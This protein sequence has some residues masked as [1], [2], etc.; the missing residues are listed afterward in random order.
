M[1]K[2][3]T[4]VLCTALAA[5]T[6]DAGQMQ[7]PLAAGSGG[8]GAPAGTGGAGGAGGASGAGGMG[9][10]GSGGM[11]PPLDAGTGGQAG[12]S[13]GM[14]GMGGA[15]GAS[16]A[17]M[18]DA[19]DR[20]DVTSEL[21]VIVPTAEWACGLPSGIPAP[22]DGELVAT[23][24]LELQAPLE[25]GA[26]PF[27]ERS[28]LLTNAGTVSGELEGTVV[29]GGY[30]WELTLP[31]GARELETRH[32]LRIG[33]ALIY[34]RG[35]GVGTASGATR[36]IMA[37]EVSGS[38]SNA[39]FQSGV[40]VATRTVRAGS[41]RFSIHRF[42]D[43][44]TLDPAAPSLTIERTARDRALKPQPWECAP[45][46][47]G[48]SEGNQLIEATVA[49]GS[50]LA[51]GSTQNGS[52]NIIPITGGSFEGLGA[53]SALSGEVIP[54]GADFQLTPPGG[55][56]QLEAR[57]T[58]RAEDGTL[59]A[60]RNCGGVGGTAPYF[61][62]PLASSYAYLNDGDYFGRIGI[63]IGA[64]IISVFERVP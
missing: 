36:V 30:D 9:S 5:C 44:F 15:A 48:S 58:L 40:Y 56:F 11:P 2:S 7:S 41:A 23:L 8:A 1:P 16:D 62:V 26:T 60:V 38:G 29:Q 21:G 55:S 47:A 4:L 52:R 37:L 57:Y 25:L 12:A 42:A 46:P 20:E 51:V 24:E 17:S 13:A 14:G 3:L 6:S 59:I 22:A 27:G 54:G 33:G 49:I 31:S 53:A 18:A 39:A 35:C 63:S 64:V 32:V 10:G 43:D 61:E 34:M 50:S 28:I 45:P 19:S